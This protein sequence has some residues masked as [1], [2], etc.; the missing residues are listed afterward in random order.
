MVA[1]ES[2]R[3][4]A[5]AGHGNDLCVTGNWMSES[6]SVHPS[7]KAK[8]D[9]Q[10]ADSLYIWR[11]DVSMREV[12]TDK[13]MFDLTWERTSRAM[14]SES[15]RRTERLTL[16]E[17]EP[18]TVDLVHNAQKSECLRVM[19]EIVAHLTE[20]PEF[21]G[22]TLDW[23]L[24][25]S[26]TQTTPVHKSLTSPQGES[27]AFQFEPILVPTT[28]PAGQ[29][30]N[31]SMHV[32]VYGQLRGRIRAD[33]NIDVAL[34]AQ[35]L[36]NYGENSQRF[37]RLMARPGDSGQKNFIIRPGEIV[38]IVLPPINPRPAVQVQTDPVTGQRTVTAVPRPAQS[39]ATAAANEMSITIQARV[40]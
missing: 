26:G 37:P 39:P 38:R 18:H 10:E 31:A 13:I 35:R 9:E 23:D 40:R 5:T 19:V 27:A 14:P 25:L 36:V 29:P 33:G 16:R 21:Y 17:G 11:F 2:K 20:D 34:N 8:I 24:W 4:N 15:V 22:K 28:R 7:F 30:G 12:A 1:G 3:M 32:H 6:G